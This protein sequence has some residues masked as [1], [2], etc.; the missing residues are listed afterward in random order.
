M[1]GL[2]STGPTLSSFIQLETVSSNYNKLIFLKIFKF[3]FFPS[4]CLHNKV[5][6]SCSFSWRRR[7]GSTRMRTWT[8]G[9]V[10]LWLTCFVKKTKKKN[11]KKVTILKAYACTKLQSV[12]YIYIINMLNFQNCGLYHISAT[13][14]QVWKG[15]QHSILHMLACEEIGLCNKTALKK[16][17]KKNATKCAFICSRHFIGQLPT[18]HLPPRHHHHH[19][20]R[21]RPFMIT[22]SAR[23]LS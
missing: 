4:K 7:E 11:W 6:Y 2:L 21:P 5:S 1:E 14:F 17:L 16:S 20:L 18:F 12:F 9:Y 19:V 13:I 10:F 15:R 3:K 8:W 22:R 23:G